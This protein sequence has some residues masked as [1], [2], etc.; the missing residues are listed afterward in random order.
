MTS[1]GGPQQHSMPISRPARTPTPLMSA[2]KKVS[3]DSGGDKWRTVR[4]LHLD[5]NCRTPVGL[6]RNVNA[7]CTSLR[8]ARSMSV[9][10][11]NA[12][13]GSLASHTRL[14]FRHDL[15]GCWGIES[16]GPRPRG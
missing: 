11:R 5:Q 4:A 9:S 12:P 10:D 3:S 13:L 6:C 14:W 15:W 16:A 1:S 2:T 8:A 7:P